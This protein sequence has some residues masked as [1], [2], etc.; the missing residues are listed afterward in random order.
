[1]SDFEDEMLKAPMEDVL[2]AALH[3][4]GSHHK[5][6]YLELVLKKVSLRFDELKRLSQWEDGVAP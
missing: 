4:D 2:I 6:W 1:M 5:Q 3:T